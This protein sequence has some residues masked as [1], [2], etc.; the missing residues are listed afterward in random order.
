MKLRTQRKSQKRSSIRQKWW[1]FGIETLEPR[2][3]PALV[4]W[5]G[6]GDGVSWGD[7]ANWD[8][9]VL[10]G[11][12]DDVVIDD[13][14]DITVNHSIGTTSIHSL[15]SNEGLTLSGGTLN[16]ATSIQVSNTFKLAGGTIQNATVLPG[17]D[18][19]GIHVTADSTLD[20]V[21]IDA[22]V[23]FESYVGNANSYLRIENGLE[24]NGTLTMTR[25]YVAPTYYAHFYSTILEV[26]DNGA[27]PDIS[28][29][30]TIRFVQQGSRRDSNR[31]NY[32]YSK[33]VG[34]TL[35]IDGVTI[36]GQDGFVGRADAALINQ[37]T[38]NAS[39]GTIIVRGLVGN[40]GNALVTGGTLDLD[41]TYTVDQTLSV[42]DG[43]LTLRG[44]STMAVGSTVLL[45]NAT[46][47][48]YDVWD[49]DGII[50]VTDSTVHLD[51]TFTLEDLGTFHRNG[52]NNAANIIGTLNNS[53]TTFTLDAAT[54]WTLGG[55]RISGGTV[56]GGGTLRVTADSTLD[57]VRMDADVDFGSYVGDAH[58]YLRIENG[59]ELNGTLTMTRSYVAPTFYAHFYSTILE[60]ADNGAD[61]DISGTGTI[62]FV[63]Q[64]SRRD[65]NRSNYVYS[66]NASETLTIAG[67]TIQG[68]DGFVGR[69]DAALI[70]HG[71]LDASAGTIV[72]RGTNVTNNGTLQSSPGRTLEVRNLMPHNGRIFADVNSTV[73]INGAFQQE[74]SGTV[75]IAINGSGSGNFGEVNIS[76]EAVLGGF[77]EVQSDDAFAPSLD[78]SFRIVHFDSRVGAFNRV[79]SEILANDLIFEVAYGDQHVTIIAA[80]PKYPDLLITELTSPSQGQ[81]GGL[82]TVD[83]TI[84][85]HGDSETPGE[86]WFDHIVLSANDS[87]GD[88]DDVLLAAVKRTGF[89][90]VDTGY[91]VS[92]D[93]RL[94]IGITGSYRIFLVTDALGEVGEDTQ[95]H[96]NDALSA[97]VIH[98]S[99]PD[100]ADLEISNVQTPETGVG[101]QRATINW[102]VDNL[103]PDTTNDGTVGGIVTRW[104]DRLVASVNDIFG[105]ADDHEL[106]VVEHVGELSI[107][108]GYD[109]VWAGTISPKLSGFYHIFVETNSSEQVY[110]YNS[111][112][113]NNVAKASGTIE[114][115]STPLIVDDF[116]DGNLGTNTDG[117]GSGWSRAYFGNSS[118]SSET[119]SAFR[120]D[121]RNGSNSNLAEI[122]SHDT[123]PI[124]NGPTVVARFHSGNVAVTRDNTST[125]SDWPG[126]TQEDWRHQFGIVSANE[127]KSGNSGNNTQREAYLYNNT[128]G[129][130]FVDIA[131]ERESD[132][133]DLT[134]V[135]RIRAAN[136]HKP[137]RT[138][139]ESTN[140]L[141]TVATFQF[142]NYD[143]QA[144]LITTITTSQGGWTVNFSEAI[145]GSVHTDGVFLDGDT[146]IGGWTADSLGDAAITDE[147][148]NG[149]Y[150]LAFVQ[151]LS[152]GRGTGDV[153]RI[154][155]I[156]TQGEDPDLQVSSVTAS[157]SFQSGA[158]LTVDW[159]V[160]NESVNPTAVDTWTDAIIL[161]TNDQLGD[162]D[163]ILLKTVSHTGV[164][165]PEG[166]YSNST[167]VT[168]PLDLA[169]DYHLFV[170][171]D[172]GSEVFE[173]NELNNGTATNITLAAPD[174][175][176]LS[177]SNLTTPARLIG[178]LSAT[179]TW[180]VKNTGPNT[181]GNGAP[182]SVVTQ[183][184]DRVVASVNEILGD[185]DDIFIADVLHQGALASQEEYQGTFHGTIPTGISGDYYVF[186][187]VNSAGDVYEYTNAASNSIKTDSTLETIPQPF[188]D[189]QPIS[190]T[191][192]PTVNFRDS[193]N[194]QWTVENTTDAVMDAP[195]EP[196]TDIVL[197]SS[198]NQ[199]G[200]TDDRLVASVT[201]HRPGQ[202][203]VGHPGFDG[204]R[205]DEQRNRNVGRQ[206]RY[207]H[208]DSRQSGRWPYPRNLVRFPLAHG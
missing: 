137:G 3:A 167:D 78:E 63:Q 131:Y 5:D 77:F 185:G 123:F 189:L 45:N 93:L 96:N 29:T 98:V 100:Y 33:N 196:W 26:A 147:F 124:L 51:G 64:G 18:D 46:L 142:D 79:I 22:D 92:H 1:K 162:G 119:Q 21:R 205:T 74:A 39:E 132:S 97:T 59:L 182:G 88:D 126:L 170:R 7:A 9:D 99:P 47:N 95:E 42:T 61:P 66:K 73:N 58:S 48:L 69:T 149:A 190:F 20:G 157:G 155:A 129:G 169:G 25:S 168:L 128:A 49:N 28:G 133:R 40:V 118:H 202:A 38:L 54:D 148:A 117:I 55:G 122:S 151:N 136:K 135:G 166:T 19:E 130:L 23:N 208:L 57:G 188:A 70:N 86:T 179:I 125:F 191:A 104:S 62:R 175:A 197:L 198:D 87:L 80:E 110:E 72:V 102:R 120:F 50:E 71:T 201:H 145:T 112:P 203:E 154:S 91:S 43:A 75:T 8:G 171:T 161:S 83:W 138:E 152:G 14:G 204:Y 163:D 15:V 116:D 164:L 115:L 90:A 32:V 113:A 176:D 34:E 192:P 31:S 134:V 68:Q 35:T 53:G 158:S 13:I 101:G 150:L 199:L 127:P 140:G 108:Q 4:T 181:T 85:N 114:I 65:S 81:S 165:D 184:T 177:V 89:L 36:Q 84:E 194:L 76:G 17:L 52:T 103:G 30:G 60:V 27:D 41:G 107:G 186:V 10:P 159:T 207:H 206:T 56:S 94:P 11:T 144:E 173:F 200:G 12:G 105:D 37:G 183:W 44:T 121:G 141:F 143:G 24:L 67:I 16:V 2:I 106:A 153:F 172:S 109:G 82:I 174:H 187:E 160:T 193:V 180:Q 139:N 195:D 156:E 178:D 146:V 6:G 111:D